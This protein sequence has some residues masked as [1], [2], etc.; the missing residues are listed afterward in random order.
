MRNRGGVALGLIV[1]L[2]GMWFLAI[3]LVPGIKTWADTM[4]YWPF[5]IVALGGVILLIGLVTG[6]SGLEVFGCIVAG[7]G[8]ILAYQNATGNWASWAYM[9]ALI[10]GFAGVGNVLGGL[11]RRKWKI[12]YDGLWTILVSV[13]LFGAFASFFGESKELTRYWPLGL[14]LMGLILLVRAVFRR[15]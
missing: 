10:P 12:L 13:I 5:Q 4:L 8:G 14:I 2:A 6:N 11:F 1:L 9:W 15:R 7:V 3:Q